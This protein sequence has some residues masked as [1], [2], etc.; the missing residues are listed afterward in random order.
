MDSSIKKNDKG[1]TVQFYGK[2]KLLIKPKDTTYNYFSEFLEDNLTE[3][4]VKELRRSS[5]RKM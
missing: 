3:R 5:K 2:K 4:T 1:I